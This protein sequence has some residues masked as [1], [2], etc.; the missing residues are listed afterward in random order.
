VVPCRSRSSAAIG[1]R[2][3]AVQRD[4][5]DF[6]T[7]VDRFKLK[8]LLQRHMSNDLFD[9]V[10]SNLRLFEQCLMWT[11]LAGLLVCRACR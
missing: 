7:A 2:S 10:Y 4:R 6:T 8:C 11:K 3:S 5:M 1:A 9:L